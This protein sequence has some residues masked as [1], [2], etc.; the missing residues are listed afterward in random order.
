MLD[1]VIVE[2]IGG[3]FFDADGVFGAMAEAGSEAV[4]EVIGDEFGFAVDEADSAFGAVWD[5]E[6]AAVAFILVDVDD[7]SGGFGC[8]GGEYGGSE[9]GGP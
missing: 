6:A 3:S 7:F 2:V 1:G 4:A 9:R 8:H 5:A